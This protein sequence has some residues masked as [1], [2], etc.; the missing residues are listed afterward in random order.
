MRQKKTV[1][2]AT[3][4]EDSTR[5]LLQRARQ[6]KR[7]EEKICQLLPE[8]LAENCSL[9][10]LQ[11][12][13]LTLTTASPAWAARLRF[14][15]PELLTQLKL[16]YSM[17]LQTVRVRILP[18]TETDAETVFVQ[19]MVLSMQNANLLA[20]TAKTVND[21]GLREALYRLAA[22]VREN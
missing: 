11:N 1:S 20:Q 14:F 19:P 6:L 4:F 8:G 18:Q 13:T 16:R 7:L 10:N 3:L 2:C 15:A 21:P 22:N 17:Q 9:M 5:P 12:G